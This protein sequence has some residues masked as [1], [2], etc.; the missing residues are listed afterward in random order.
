MTARGFN[1]LNEYRALAR[2]EGYYRLFRQRAEENAATYVKKARGS[3]DVGDFAH[4]DAILALAARS[5]IDIKLVIYPYHAQTLALFEASGL[6]PA[7]EQWKQHVA[8]Q[9]AAT[10]QR[11]P[12]ARVALVDFSG[13][14]STACERIPAPADF[15]SVTTWYWEGGHFKKT[16]GEAM[17]ANL[18]PSETPRK[19]MAKRFGFALEPGNADANAHRIGLERARCLRDYPA[20]FDESA[21][22]VTMARAASIKIDRQ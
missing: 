1:P 15:S 11:D 12:S 20:L 14:S 19:L 17:L 10:K 5:H 7:F 3:V 8:T 18:L 9:A 22:L 16:L 13:Y 21:S 2:T 4:L 6:W